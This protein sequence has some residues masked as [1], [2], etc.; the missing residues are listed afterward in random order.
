MM[1]TSFGAGFEVVSVVSDS[2]DTHRVVQVP[3]TEN[4]FLRQQEK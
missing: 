3:K 4:V 2:N 1:K